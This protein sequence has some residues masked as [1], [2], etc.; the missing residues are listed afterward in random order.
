M[1]MKRTPPRRGRPRKDYGVESLLE[2]YTRNK[3][4]PDWENKVEEVTI[5]NVSSLLQACGAFRSALRRNRKA[6][7]MFKRV[8]VVVSPQ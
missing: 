8:A 5:S 4:L 1:Y 6:G 2:A 7:K 3:V